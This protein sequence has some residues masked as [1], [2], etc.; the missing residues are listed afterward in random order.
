[1]IFE[2][3]AL[4]KLLSQ[5]GQIPFTVRFEDKDAML[6]GNGE[7]VFSVIVHNPISKKELIH[8]TSLALGEAYMNHTIEVDGDLFT[9]LNIVLSQID[10]FSVNS[11]A[12]DKILHSSTK[13]KNQKQE[14]GY[15]YN[16]GNDFYRLWLDETLSYSCAYFP[17]GNE[18]L[19]EAQVKK[20][21]H[22][23]SKLQLK[24]DMQ[25]LDI[26]CGWGY[27]LIA[28]AKEYG[29][30]GTG[31][32]LSE[33]QHKECCRKAK[34]EGLADQLTFLLMDYRELK[35]SHLQFDRV[36]SVGMLEHVGRE[37][38]D[39]FFENVDSVLKPQGIFLLHY[40]SALKEH[41]GDPWLKKYI[42][43][44]GVI[45]SL[46]EILHIAGDYGYCTVDV[47]SLRRH[48]V[49]TLLCWA[50]KFQQNRESVL[51]MFDEK[52]VRMWE[53]YLSACAASFNNGV[54]DLHQLLLT[55]GV[56]NTIPMI[57]EEYR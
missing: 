13:A 10:K 12:L 35:K 18:T 6:V 50:E 19:Y 27:L 42:F 8:S 2:K 38:Y 56:N 54:I 14:V 25:L 20:T 4:K 37:N 31:I 49:K 32:T 28:A 7:P 16:I 5:M 41:P 3:A 22:L 53:L 43:P 45:P 55:K 48:Y 34:E 11:K 36:V 52:F 26:G 57:R 1:M 21:Y 9:A 51:S 24:R 40:I 29:I 44:G 15:H 23:I 39:L 30:K 47:E 46:R 33:E 17:R